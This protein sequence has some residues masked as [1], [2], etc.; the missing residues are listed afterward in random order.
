MQVSSYNTED[1]LGQLR[2]AGGK[3]F[4]GGAC[5]ACIVLLHAA[6]AARFHF[7]GGGMLVLVSG[8]A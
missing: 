5:G 7:G 4:Y 8:V 3:A 1:C 6:D 2:E